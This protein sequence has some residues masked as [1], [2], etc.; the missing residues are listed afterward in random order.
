MKLKFVDYGYIALCCVAGIWQAWCFNYGPVTI[1]VA[2]GLPFALMTYSYA[3]FVVRCRGIADRPHLKVIFFIP[4]GMLFSLAIGALAGA[5][6]VALETTIGAHP[7][8]K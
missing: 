5:I 1:V 2:M 6:T 8:F 7:S 3:S 4:I